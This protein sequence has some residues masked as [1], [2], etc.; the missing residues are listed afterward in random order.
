M[1]RDIGPKDKQSRR[2]GEKLFLKGERDL[3]PKS[4]IVKRNYP[5]GIHGPKGFARKKSDYGR[6]LSAKQKIKKMY[7]LRER[8]FRNYFL[9]GRKQK[10]NA[11]ENLLRLLE[12]RLDNV[13]YR[14]G[15]AH[16]RDQA[17]QLVTHGHIRL[18]GKKV[19]IPSQLVKTRDEIS[20]RQSSQSN[21]FFQ[22]VSKEM[23]KKEIPAWLAYV[24]KE[25]KGVVL[26]LPQT[27]DLNLDQDA[28]LTVE[29]YSR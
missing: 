24:E 8:Q 18:N 29:F 25:K 2:L 3:S 16:S 21:K 13:V 20:V 22:L 4:A 9:Q 15:F 14:F 6:Q 7:R 10:G 1:G 12:L 26:D 28:T 11:S 19:N 5:P 17:R 23:S 27:K